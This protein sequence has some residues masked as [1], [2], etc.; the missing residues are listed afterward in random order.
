LIASLP[1]VS[2]PL[3]KGVVVVANLLILGFDRLALA[4]NIGALDVALKV[5]GK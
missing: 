3:P 4:N 2:A 5:K 1:F